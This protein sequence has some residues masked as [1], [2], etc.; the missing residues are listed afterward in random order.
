MVHNVLKSH[1]ISRILFS[2]P[3]LP[4]QTDALEDH[5]KLLQ[6]GT[7]CHK[8]SQLWPV[9]GVSFIPC[10]CFLYKQQNCEVYRTC[11]INGAE[12]GRVCS[13]CEDKVRY[14]RL[15]FGEREGRISIWNT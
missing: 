12:L 15:L 14:W 9:G 5:F 4:I 7:V 2:Y 10:Q 6:H 8:T 1:A 13:M 3:S 11:Q